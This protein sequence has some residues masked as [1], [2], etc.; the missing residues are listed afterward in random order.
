MFLCCN[1]AFGSCDWT[2]IKKNADGTYTYSAELNKCVGALVQTNQN[3]A[4]AV[5]DMTKAISMKD[6]SIQA[7][8]KRADDWNAAAKNLEDRL[9]K[10]D[11]TEETN[12]FIYFGLGILATGFAA[13]TASKLR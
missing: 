2:K 8:D 9:Q 12:K 7:S 13:Y 10:V 3:Q 11:K 5:Q 6:L 1:F 4:Q